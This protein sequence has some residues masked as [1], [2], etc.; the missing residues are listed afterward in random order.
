ML[1]GLELTLL[2][3]RNEKS[4]LDNREEAITEKINDLVFN[5]FE[6]LLT[7]CQTAI[8]RELLIYNVQMMRS[9]LLSAIRACRD[10]NVSDL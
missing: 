10:G 7:L 6:D 1:F 4:S 5:K 3:M 9:E 2:E 8:P